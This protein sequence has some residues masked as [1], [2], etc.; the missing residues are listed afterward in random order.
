M[1]LGKINPKQNLQHT[2]LRSASEHAQ[3]EMR[4]K[5]QESQAQS[6][7]P[8]RP[9]LTQRGLGVPWSLTG[10]GNNELTNNIKYCYQIM[11]VNPCYGVLR[12]PPV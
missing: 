1:Q 4:H 7:E 8:E 9:L 11:K 10:K 3:L 12:N 5:D 6:R 2:T